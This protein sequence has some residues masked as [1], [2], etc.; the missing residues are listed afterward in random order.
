MGSRLVRVALLVL[1]ASC[2]GTKQHP[3]DSV[4]EYA[5]GID[6]DGDGTVDFPD[7]LG[8]TTNTDG[9]EDSLLSAQCSDGRDNDGD[10]RKD[11]PADPGCF[12]PQ[13]DDE[14]DECPDGT[15]CPECSDGVDN[16]DNGKTDYPDDPGCTSA[17][18]DYEFKTNPVACGMGLRIEQLPTSGEA[19]GMLDSSSTSGMTFPCGSPDRP[20]RAY[21][22]HLSQ[23]QVVEIS[24]DDARTTVNT[25]IDLRAQ[26]CS[27]D[28]AHMTCSD[29]ISSQ[30]L[31]SKLTASLPAG[32]YYV[33]VSGAEQSSTG[34]FY[35]RVT[36]HPGEGVACQS[37]ADCGPGL[38]C[39]VL[40]GQTDQACA[41][42][43]CNDGVDDDGDGDG[44]GYPEDPGCSSP[45]DNDEAD[46]CP[47]GPG[48][49][50]CAD[51]E[52]NDGDGTTDFPDDMSCGAASDVSEHCAS[53]DGVALL[54]GPVTMGSTAG[55]FDDVSPTCA[56][57][58]SGADLAYGLELPALSALQ[59]RIDS[60]FFAAV[61][62]L[63]ETCSAPEL[64][65]ELGSAFELTDVAAGNYFLVIDGYDDI[66]YGTFTLHVTGTIEPGASCEG[67]L[68]ASGALACGP[69]YA[70]KGPSE[71]RTC[72][73]ALCVDGLDNDGDTLNDFPFDPGCSSP[74][75]DTEDDDCPSGPNCPVCANTT[76]D[77]TDALTDWPSDYGCTSAAGTSE[78]FCS[79][80][81]DPTSLLTAPQVTGT[82][83]G[84]TSDLQTS[85]AFSTSP[86]LSYALS[87]PVPVTSLVV[88]TIGSQF[89][90][91]VAVQD[92]SCT[93]EFGCDDQAGG[94]NTSEV[95]LSNLAAG[96]YAITVT[97]WAGEAGPYTL[98]VHGT[99]A[100]QT[101]CNSQ[102]FTAGVLSCPTGTACSGNPKKCQ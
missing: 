76:D 9:S 47:S 5:D 73:Q 7:D 62:L 72:Q 46:D 89:D 49:P 37:E 84:L 29:D 70:C 80:E 36:K 96:N 90:T 61:V 2:S 101:A 44:A 69:G 30:N 52:D 56:D 64:T 54:P 41:K 82:T 59:V 3:A 11:Y 100:P 35:L 75:D 55:A 81:T 31:K 20:A 28:G 79:L 38:A 45:I 83:A 95:I 48:C 17:S 6:N 66:E 18:D 22:L 16:D 67:D 91:V 14:V 88:D 24:T 92:A 71:G 99:V 94:N 85:C 10:G 50:A 74:S 68:A 25:V 51:G 102:L 27:D 8:C 39:R 97:G 65:C 19:T 78:Q 53:R 32:N 15:M 86:D 58:T 63:G 34:P 87:L 60:S 4:P 23:P 12:A 42:P 57:T 21:E 43:M 40:P 26:N 93:I 1:V 13:Q 33:V 98:N 77:D